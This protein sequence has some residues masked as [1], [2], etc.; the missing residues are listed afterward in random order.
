[1]NYLENLKTEANKT[2]TLNGA[3][4]HGSTGDACLDFFAVAGGMRY[5]R[6]ADQIALFD[7][8]YIETP[9]LAMKL[10]F[11]LRD[12]RC[13]MGERKLF[14][15][16]LRHVA[17]TW[18]ASAAKN[19][20]WIAEFGRWDDVFCLLGTPAEQQAAEV[21]RDRL[22]A[23]EAALRRRESGEA[24]AHISLLAKWLP[25][26]NA[27][28]PLTR[29]TAARLIEALGMQ[30]RDYRRLVTA[31]RARIGLTERQLT[32]RRAGRINYEA[33]PAQAMLKYRGAFARR[34]PERF[35][36]YL[37]GVKAGE[38]RI[39]TG[40]LFPYEVLRP[41]F[42]HQYDPDVPLRD[43]GNE[44]L[45]QLWDHL[46]GAVANTNAISVV[47]TSGSMYCSGGALLPA[48][49]SQAMGLYCAERC[50]GI[51][52]NHMITFESVPH[53]VEIHGETLEDKLRYLYTLPVGGSTN[54]EA[55]FD[56]IL[57]TAVKY[58]A[59]QEELPAVIYIFSDMEFNCCMQNA[60][61]TV[62]ENARERFEA[63]GYRM[64]AVVFQNV[65]SWQMQA[66]V[67]ARTRGTALASGAA[68]HTME[69][70]FD[71]NITPMDHMLRVLNSARYAMIHA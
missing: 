15:T 29:K 17:C 21:I 47:D 25:S 52:H 20:P 12:I 32:R 62:Y 34:D 69:H 55:V 40:T 48:L 18:P 8:A 22:A 38:K 11:H 5:R 50:K 2:L 68:T 56:L 59:R 10:L 9:E 23:D 3:V 30:V 51:F 49:V 57:N 44:V 41:F 71:G 33:V 24:D 70:D 42:N 66:P 45:Q 13:G 26:D 53:L 63:R 46:C 31:L 58:G 27:S 43:M 60:D 19:I 39:H 6:K 16:L 37:A 67:M 4:T 54:L 7:R 14:R 61:K 1:M 36:G 64:P 28:S 65:N 35:S